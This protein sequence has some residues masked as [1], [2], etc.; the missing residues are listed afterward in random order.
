MAFLD[1]KRA[2][3]LTS[4]AW[5]CQP[6]FFHGFSIEEC[7]RNLFIG[8]RLM[9]ILLKKKGEQEKMKMSRVSVAIL[10]ASLL[11]MMVAFPSASALKGTR[12]E[13]LSVTFY[14]T[15]EAAYTALSTGEIDFILYELTSS[16]AD[17]AFTNPNLVTAK[18]PSSGFYEFDLNNNYSI[19]DY[20]G[21][22]SPMNYTE[23]RQA[24]AFLS[25][26]DY[27][28][29]TLLGGKAVRIDQMIAAPYY[30]WANASMS[31][32][33]YPYEY[34]PAAAKAKLDTTFPVGTTPNPY[35]DAGNPLSS[36]YLR[37]YPVGHSK[38]GMDLDPMKFKVRSDSTPRLEAGRGVVNWMRTLGVPIDSQ[39]GSSSTLH[40]VVMADFNY[41]F[42]TGG[43][44]V[45]RFPPLSLYGLYHSINAFSE[46]SN[47]VTGGHFPFVGDNAT[48][49]RLY[50]SHPILDQYLYNCNYALT[51]GDAVKYCKLAAGY[52]TEIC[53]NVPCWSASSFWVWNKNLLGVVGMQGDDP[54]NGYTFQNAYK[55][56]GSAIR[57]GTINFPPSVNIVYSN[58]VYSYSVLDRMTLYGGI[59]VP[60][61]NVAADQA[62]FVTNWET[63]TWDGGT[64]T[65]VRMTL[66][67]DGYF[68]KPVSGDQGENVNASYYFW[69]AWLDFQVGDGWFSTGFIDLHHVDITGP[70]SFDIYFNSLSYWNT[71]YCQ[72]PLRPM[73]TWMAQGEDFI[74]QTV[75]TFVDP[76][77]P[78]AINMAGDP[79]WIDYVTFDGTPL[80]MFTDYNIVLGK[81]YIYSTLGTGTLEVSYHYITTPTALRGTTSG[82]LAWQT[83]FE[84][85]GQYYCTAF[86]INT[87]A[88][89]KRNPFYYMVTPPLGEIDF[90][91]KP[92]GNYKVDIFDLAL[93]GGAF[94]SQ[95]TGVPSSNW[96]A[97]ADL[98]PNG[99]VVDIYD[100]V[101][102]TGVNWD[103]EFD[104]IQ[105]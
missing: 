56:D 97:G 88:T 13:D 38:A 52:M 85:A 82:G 79:I 63:T 76:T 31:Y 17:N 98:A 101:T 99:G 84:G 93:A 60:A 73:D 40:P 37:Q 55:T 50:R 72:G 53:V 100:E 45:G 34:S 81:L 67:D 6:C 58:W 11:L 89:F 90:V 83:I 7:S 86:N 2:L 75:E 64:K 26:K 21:I 14:A 1:E 95:G 8:N 105:P 36:P 15:Q 30:G 91:K 77:T 10:F 39:E 65:L 54:E 57:C 87:A 19:S 3:A 29:D 12:G 16:Q 61:Y 42:Y 96:F 80:T 102:V 27:Y 69:N 71:Y 103:Q 48:D 20:P 94:G 18:V 92:D 51:Y 9:C 32:P 24:V 23:M 33:Y 41:H 35:Y 43:W 78:G 66:R 46:G 5:W 104:P 47:Y 68:A 25:D 4:V 70:Y 62:G 49:P 28:V 44:S 22:R 59:D 74:N